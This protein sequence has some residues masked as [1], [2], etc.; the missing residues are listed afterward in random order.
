MDTCGKVYLNNI[1]EA[2]ILDGVQ[3]CKMCL[4]ERKAKKEQLKEELQEIEF[5]IDKVSCEEDMYYH[6]A[7]KRPKYREEISRRQSV[8]NDRLKELENHKEIINTKIRYLEMEIEY[9]DD[10][11]AKYSK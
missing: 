6:L 7:E 9:L 3:I 1:R 10:K 4:E 5:K 8:C 11:L 2:L